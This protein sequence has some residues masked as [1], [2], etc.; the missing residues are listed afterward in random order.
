MKLNRRSFLLGAVAAA[1]LG[2][3]PAWARAP[4]PFDARSFA[5]AQAAGQPIL[6]HVTAVWCETCQRQKPIV[7]K[8]MDQR[9][10]A[11]MALFGVDFDKQ[12]DALRTFKAQSQSTMIVFKGKHEVARAVGVTDPAQIEALLRRAL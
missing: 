11:G 12:R 7:A 4:T 10:F 1:T 5:V 9:D 3:A 6:V 2:P 8:L